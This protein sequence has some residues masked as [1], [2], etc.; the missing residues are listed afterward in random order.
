MNVP[1]ATYSLRMSFWTVPESAA[2]AM[3]RRFAVATYIA[4]RMMAV[5][6]IVI[7]VDTRSSGMSANR[8]SMSSIESIAPPTRPTSP[9]ASE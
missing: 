6:L 1:R 5:E 3:P 7:E 9:A 4:S 8:T 2:G